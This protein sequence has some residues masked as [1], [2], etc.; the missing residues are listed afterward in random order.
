M[1]VMM[2]NAP[3]ASEIFLVELTSTPGWSAAASISVYRDRLRVRYHDP[4]IAAEAG[5][6]HD[7]AE[8]RPRLRGSSP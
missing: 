3:A 6:A 4:A 7:S 2:N 5:A 8:L 1:K